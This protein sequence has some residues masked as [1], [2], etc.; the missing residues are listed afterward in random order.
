MEAFSEPHFDVVAWVNALVAEAAE[1]EKRETSGVRGGDGKNSAER[2][3]GGTREEA[4]VPMVRFEEGSVAS[5]CAVCSD[6]SRFD[7][8]TD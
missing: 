5:V 3:A 1:K 7:K 4:S 6:V 2:S 8:L